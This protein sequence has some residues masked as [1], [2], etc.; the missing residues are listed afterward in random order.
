MLRRTKAFHT[1]KKKGQST[2]EY[3]LLVAGV[4][5]VLVVFLGPNGAFQ[6]KYH[7]A[8]NEGTDGMANMAHRLSNSHSS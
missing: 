1:K 4:I 3:I 8:L 7:T 2:V 6:T 5:A